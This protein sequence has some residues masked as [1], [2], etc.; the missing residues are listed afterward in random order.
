MRYLLVFLSLFCCFNQ[1]IADQP[2]HWQIGLQESV[3]P[4]MHKLAEL[5]KHQHQIII[6]IVIFILLLLTYVCIRFRSS[7][8]KTPSQSSH[9]ATLEI[10]WTLIPVAIIISIVIPSIKILYF[11][12]VIPEAE[13]NIKVTAHQ[14]YWE[15]QYPDHGNFSFDSMIIPD[16]KLKEGELRLLAVDN[17]VVVPINTN[18]RIL[19]TSADVIHSWGVPSFGVKMDAVPGKINETWINVDKPGTYYGQCYELCGINHAFMPITVE[20]KSKED[21]AIW[22]ETAKQKYVNNNLVQKNLLANNSRIKQ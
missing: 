21:F 10:I 6:G 16:D 4:V 5:N 15:Y 7:S 18:I 9:N 2:H 20:V 19:I 12:N 14:W 17:K 1:A 22:V 11:A 3:T 8:N 13:M